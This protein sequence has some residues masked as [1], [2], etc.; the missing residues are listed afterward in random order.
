MHDIIAEILSTA[1]VHQS[2]YY[3][4]LLN[5]TQHRHTD[6]VYTYYMKRDEKTEAARA[7]ASSSSVTQRNLLLM[8]MIMNETL[9]S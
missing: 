5:I 4:S 9:S 3:T 1:A 8:L 7:D 6:C 2:I